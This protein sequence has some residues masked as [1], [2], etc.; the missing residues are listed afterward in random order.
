VKISK[1]HV[2]GDWLGQI[3]PH[4]GN[5][6]HT[7][8]IIDWPVAAP[9]NEPPTI[10][11]GGGQGHSGTKK[12]KVVCATCNETW[13]STKIENATK[14]ILIPLIAGLPVELLIADQGKLATWAAKTVMTAEHVNKRPP[15]ILQSER[16][17]LMGTLSPPPGWFIFATPYS[18]TE[19]RELGIFQHSGRLAV[20]STEN[21][22]ETDHHIGLTFFGMSHLLLLVL[23]SSWSRAWAAFNENDLMKTLRIWPPQQTSMQWLPQNSITDAETDYLTTYMKRILERYDSESMAD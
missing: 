19:W 11:I 12:V 1:E 6:T 20:S 3:F 21:S 13:L 18:G 8:G 16:T 23:Y 22:I 10:T 7:H 14:P 2:F 5:S 4:A 17:W 15:A 9:N